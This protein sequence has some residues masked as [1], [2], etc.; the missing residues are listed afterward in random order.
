M[1]WLAP[2]VII[3]LLAAVFWDELPFLT[4]AWGSLVDASPAPIA[5]ATCTA[6][7]ALASMSAVMQILLNIEGRIA[8]PLNTNAIVYASNAWSTTVPGGPAISA[9]LTFRVHRSWGASVGLCGWFFVISGAL[10]TSWM[11]VLGVTAVLLLGADLSVATLVGTLLLASA[12]IWALFWATRHPD[13]IKRWVGFL[14][15]SV[16]GRVVGVVDQ[17][18][19]I[20]MTT[21]Q[22]AAAAAFSLLNLLFDIGTLI[23]AVHA[24]APDSI[25]ISGIVLAFI[26]TKLAGAAQVTPGGLGTVEPVLAGML[27]AGGMTLSDAAAT[28][29]VYRLISFALI[30]TIGW[31]IYAAVY[32]RGTARL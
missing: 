5:A 10:S 26:V 1:R 12:A 13:V 14:P 3:A 6:I 20:R 4:E 32:A 18:A 11:V 29:A 28:T 17:V 9:W 27:V 23:F 16:R 22:F 24:V 25:S 7:L 19:A 8:N 31:V 30:T 21:R 2:V 15:E